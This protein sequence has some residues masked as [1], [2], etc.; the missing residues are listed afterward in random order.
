MRMLAFAAGR[1]RRRVVPAILLLTLVCAGNAAAQSFLGTVRGTVVDPQGAAVAGAAILIVDEATGVPRALET[2]AQGRYEA[3]NIKPGTYR[4]EVVTT[5]FKKFERPG[6]LVRAPAT[7]LIDVTLELGSVNETVTVIGRRGQQHH[8]R[9]PGDR[10]R[11]RRAAAARPAA[12]QPR[13]PVVPAPQPERR[14]RQR[15]DIQFLGGKTYGVSYIQDGQ[16]STNAI[17]GTIGNSAPG[18]DAISE[19]QVLSNSYSAEYGGLAGVIVT[20]KRGS[21]SVPAGPSFYDFN[22]DSLNALTYNQTL[23]GVERG[24]PLSDTHEHRWGASLGGPLIGQQA[25][26]LRQ[27][28]RVE[29]QGHLR[30]RPGDGADRRRCGTATSAAL[31][32]R[33]RIRRPGVPFPNQMIPGQPHRS[34]GD[35]T[36]WTSSIRCRTRERSRA[37]TASSSSSSP[38]RGSGSDSTSVSTT[39]RARTTR[40]SCAASYQHRNPN[41]DHLRGRQRA[42][43]PADPES[44]P[45]HRRRWSAAGRRSSARRSSTSCA[46]ATTTT[47]RAARARSARPTWRRTLGIENAPSL[48]ARSPRL[49]VV[50]VHGAAPTGRPT[51]PTPAAT[52]TARVRQ[53][54][55]SL[56]DNLTWI[57]GGHTLKAGGLWT[58]NMARDGFGLRRQLPRPVPVQR[59]VPPATPSPTSCSACPIDVPRSGHQPRSARWPLERRRRASRRTTGRS[60]RA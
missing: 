59:A 56:S 35:R 21:S 40:S 6:V 13:H 3:T 11:P 49:P 22:S 43:E 36:S 1:V 31:R 44:R 60:A 45:R 52:S 20:T 38:R 27:L 28:R 25:V 15:D 42:D 14:R 23:S 34:G 2:D 54:A 47:T 33:R 39:R 4:V 57:K 26:L 48:D 17:F 29:R 10:A 7:A 58:R 32:S 5:N 16:A 46:P 50:P 24:D 53:N 18:L 55:F 19:L 51:S 41:S 37:D 30:R 12:Q 8:A 9:Q